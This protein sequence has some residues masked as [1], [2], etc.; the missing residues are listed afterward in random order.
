MII[1]T[2]EAINEYEKF[3][4]IED[5]LKRINTIKL[6]IEKLKIEKL[7][8]ESNYDGVGSV[9]YTEGRST[10]TSSTVE[11]EVLRKEKKI[12][13]INK[14]IFSKEIQLKKINIAINSLREI[15]KKVIEERYIKEKQWKVIAEELSITES[16]CFQI[17]IEAIKEMCNFL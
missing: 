8:V 6:E 5:I 15:K 10:L 14:L 16:R 13:Q 9:G 17:R 4:Y 12:E 3:N 7:E 1:G 2:I 11:N